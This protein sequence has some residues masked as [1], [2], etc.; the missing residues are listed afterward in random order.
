MDD[1]VWI[2]GIGTAT[3]LGN[4]L[5][6]VATAVL[7]GRSAAKYEAVRVTAIVA[8]NVGLAVAA[9]VL[10][11]A[12]IVLF[13][14]IGLGALAGANALGSQHHFE[15]D[16]HVRDHEQRVRPAQRF[17][18]GEAERDQRESRAWLEGSHQRSQEPAELPR[19][20]HVR[21]A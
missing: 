19:A 21:A 9:P 11:L 14:I 2:T 17:R 16:A 12:Y 13:P 18:R 6:E 4:S 3:P 5:D 10:G 20:L 15:T 1:A 7:A 8:K